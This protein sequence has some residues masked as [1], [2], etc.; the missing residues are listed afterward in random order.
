MLLIG[1]KIRVVYLVIL[2]ALINTNCNKT[3]IKNSNTLF[4]LLK[5]ETTNID[6]VNKI[7]ETPTEHIYTFNYVYNGAG[8]AIIDINNDGLQDVFLLE[9]KRAIGYTLIKAILSLRIFQNLLGSISLKVGTVGYQR[10]IS[11]VMVMLIFIY[12][13]VGFEY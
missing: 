12:A 13:E 9:I 11:I 10:L 8:V 4:T 6:F 3:E 2:I 5:P 7:Q 1:N